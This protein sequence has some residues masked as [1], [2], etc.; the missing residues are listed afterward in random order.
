MFAIH[1]SSC[2]LCTFLIHISQCVKVNKQEGMDQT[3]GKLAA[4]FETQRC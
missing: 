2:R 4:N 1:F 3:A